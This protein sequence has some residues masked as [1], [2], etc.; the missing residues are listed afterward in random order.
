MTAHNVVHVMQGEFKISNDPR[1]VLRTVLGSCIAAC[2]RDPIAGLG[3]MNHFLL[4]GDE[5]GRDGAVR[6]G[7]HLMELLVNNLMRK[8]A[9]RRRLEAK[10]F[11]GARMMSGL[12]DIGRRN[13]EFARS[14]LRNEGIP[15]IEE[16]VGGQ[17]SRRVNYWPVSGLTDHTIAKV[18]NPKFVRPPKIEYGEVDLF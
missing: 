6:Y 3:G 8:G 12:S 10:I 2:L 5:N 1:V 15:I 11:G 18:S 17:S 16:D 7:V 4:P 13:A 9:D 14:F